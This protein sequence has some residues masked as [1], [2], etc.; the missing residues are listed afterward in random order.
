MLFTL[1]K[2]FKSSLVES[3][4]P[5]E[6]RCGKN[7]GLSNRSH[8]LL[9]CEKVKFAINDTAKRQIAFFKIRDFILPFICLLFS[10]CASMFVG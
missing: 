2:S 7:P 8:N 9:S 10:Y 4:R 1:I 6:L 3:K 5:S